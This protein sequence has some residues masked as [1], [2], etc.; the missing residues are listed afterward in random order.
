MKHIFGIDVGGT[1]VKIGLFDEEINLIDK[2]EIITDKRDNGKNILRDIAESIKE[3]T[4]KHGILDEN[5]LG[6]GFGIPGPVINNY[7]PRC[8]NLGWREINIKDEF[9][10]YIDARVVCANNDANVAALGEL[11]KGGG[12]GYKN[13]VMFTLGTGVGGGIIVDGKIVEGT[14]GAGGELG[15]L[16]IVNEN[17]TECGCGR[18]GCLETVAS[19]TGIVR[20]AKRLYEESPV[21]TTLKIDEK[22]TC[23]DVFDAAK[24]EDEFALKVI[25]QFGYYMGLAAS[26]VCNILNPEVIIIGGGVSKAGQIIVEQIK[27]YYVKYCFP[28]LESTKFEL[29][30]LGNDAG[31]IGAACLVK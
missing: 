21:K 7:V 24:K 26:Y 1:T 18:R 16:H 5:I 25:D 30:T 2:W 3:Y 17:A 8:V 6:Y 19:A 22:I 11:N 12:Q 10:K 31:M 4:L 9:R 23:K 15:H 29:A 14:N 27:K 13:A 20:E 28:G